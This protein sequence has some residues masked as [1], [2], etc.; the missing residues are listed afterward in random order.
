[1]G[2][3]IIS[4]YDDEIVSKYLIDQDFNNRSLIK[5]I[6]DNNLNTLLSHPKTTAFLDYQWIG[7]SNECDGTLDDSSIICY[8]R[9]STLKSIKGKKIT[10]SD[11]LMMRYK[12]PGDERNY[13]V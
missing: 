2:E 11:R 6:V 5:I 12:W 8:L 3:Q 1:M 13:P 4:S 9:T 7:A 10:N